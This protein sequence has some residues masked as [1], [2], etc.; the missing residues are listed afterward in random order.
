MDHVTGWPLL[1][2]L[3]LYLQILIMSLQLQIVDEESIS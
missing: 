3:M 2:L 1:E